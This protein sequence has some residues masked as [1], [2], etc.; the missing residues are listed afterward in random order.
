MTH[1]DNMIDVLVDTEEGAAIDALLQ[2][3][4]EQAKEH[5]KQIFPEL[6][7]SVKRQDLAQLSNLYLELNEE[8][9]RWLDVLTAYN[10]E[11]QRAPTEEAQKRV[12][13]A[14][15]GYRETF[16]VLKAVETHLSFAVRS[17]WLPPQKDGE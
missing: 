2:A 12:A 14:Q 10:H 1:N 7:D 11:F 15:L 13:T 16:Y 9:R 3:Q 6:L 17:E 8:Y 4:A 5:A